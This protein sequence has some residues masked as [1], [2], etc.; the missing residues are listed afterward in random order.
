M[1]CERSVS[2]ISLAEAGK[3]ENARGSK[4]TDGVPDVWA[5]GGGAGIGGGSFA[6][7]QMATVASTRTHLRDIVREEERKFPR[8][9]AGRGPSVPAGCVA[10]HLKPSRRRISPVSRSP[11][12]VPAGL[13]VDLWTTCN[14]GTPLDIVTFF[15]LHQATVGGGPRTSLLG[16][17]NPSPWT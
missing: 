16:E 1:V 4:S 14:K 5:G 3:W 11:V 12:S 2:P 10:A 17:I 13:G 15:V 6:L 9:C 8:L 7:A